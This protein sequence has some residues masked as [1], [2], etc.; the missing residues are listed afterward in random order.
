MLYGVVFVWLIYACGAK[1]GQS[2]PV[3]EQHEGRHSEHKRNQC[4][5]QVISSFNH[6]LSLHFDQVGVGAKHISCFDY[7]T[8]HTHFYYWILSSQYRTK[9]PGRSMDIA[10]WKHTGF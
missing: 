5:H 6:V 3:S 9:S 4:R 7:A 1:C 8:I 2:E 10:E